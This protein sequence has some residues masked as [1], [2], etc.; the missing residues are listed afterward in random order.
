M[1]AAD[2]TPCKGCVHLGKAGTIPCCNYILDTGHSRPCPAGEGCAEKRTKGG[3]KL[4]D[5]KQ[6]KI[7]KWDHE[8]ARRLFDEG[9][10]YQQ[11][12]QECGVHLETVKRWLRKQGLHRLPPPRREAAQPSEAAQEPQDATLLP[13]TV[14]DR[15]AVLLSPAECRR[16]A[17]ILETFVFN[18]DGATL[19]MQ[20]LS[21]IVGAWRTLTEAVRG[22]ALSDGV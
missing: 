10:T 4:V 19:S 8:L 2:M 1:S 22:E 13:L 11:I 16:T 14:D 7:A 21:E 3:K 20:D 12:A 15:V 18:V 6:P 17:K 9:A 5:N